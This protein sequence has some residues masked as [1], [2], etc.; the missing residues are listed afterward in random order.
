MET[1]L[2]G[3]Q[4]MDP[5]VLARRHRRPRR[6]RV[7][8][9][10][11]A[12]RA[13]RRGSIRL[14]CAHRSVRR[15]AARFTRFRRDHDQDPRT[16]PF[17]DLGDL[18]IC[19]SRPWPVT[20]NCL[21]LETVFL[22]AGGVFLYPNWWRVRRRSPGTASSVSPEALR[23]PT[24]TRGAS[25][26]TEGHRRDNRREPRLAVLR[27]RSSTHAGSHALGGDGAALAELHTYHAPA[28]SGSYVPDDVRAGARGAARARP[29]AR[30]RVERQRH[31]AARTWTRLGLTARFDCVLDSRTRG[32]RSR[33]RACSRSRWQRSGAAQGHDDSRRRPV[34]RRR[35]RR[36]KRRAAR[37]AAR[38]GR[39]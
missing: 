34:L 27:S 5:V 19:G 25:S 8:G 9:V 32:S 15:P 33:I 38:R 20:L 39:S 18:V 11:R 2:F 35:R 36:A 31:A 10:R 1:Q 37:R 4:P 7:A 13:A 17:C 29:A 23:R 21:V 3:V 14:H 12:R 6:R 28:T 26:T 16:H 30:R 24:R 22:D